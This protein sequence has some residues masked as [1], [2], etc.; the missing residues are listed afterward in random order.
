MPDKD[1]RQ[2]AADMLVYNSA[3][4]YLA[5]NG[6]QLQEGTNLEICVFGSWIP[7]Q[8]ALDGGGWYLTTLDQVGIRLH[9]GLPARS[10][11]FSITPSVVEPPHMPS[12]RILLV[13]D[14][15]A[16]LQAL[17]RVVAL[18]LPGVL[19]DTS[20]TPEE[21]LL[22]IQQSKYEAIVCD[23]KMPGM[24]GLTLLAQSRELQPETPTLLI[25]GHGDHTLAIQ[26]LRGGA[27]DYIQKP[28]D[29]DEFIASLLRAIQV[30]QLRRHVEEQ[31]RALESHTRSLERLVQQRTQELIEA[32]TTKDKVIG[33]V[34][35]ELNEPI[36]RLKDMLNLLRQKLSSEDVAEIVRHSFSDIEQ[37]LGRIEVL[38]QELLTASGI[39]T[40]IF[41][42]HKKHCNLVEVCQKI[43][44]EDTAGHDLQISSERSGGAVAVDVDVDQMRLVLNALLDNA[45]AAVG[46]EG[47][48]TITLQQTGYEAIITLRD[49][50][51]RNGLGVGFYISRKIVE[52]HGG[53][54]EVQDFPGDKRALFMMLPLLDEAVAVKTSSTH[55]TRAVWTLTR[56]S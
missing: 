1:N 37:S 4:N 41:I 18:R 46:E 52:R 40:Q 16:L 2:T 30:C 49:H 39:E 3:N 26:A 8:V 22:R 28:I 17:P 25:T 5:L 51:A 44:E 33:I 23:I 11:E 56:S 19:V 31:Q 55:R 53:H 47:E 12:S 6:H 21:A 20:Q 32:H 38:V 43:L 13:D 36:T 35:Y 34:S 54:L 29:R 9:T 15:K 42:L 24:D 27:Y 14:D 50:G 45:S 10:A 7:G 48:A